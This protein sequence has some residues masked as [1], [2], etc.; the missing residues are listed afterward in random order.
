MIKPFKNLSNRNIKELTSIFNPEN[1][2]I[3]D[4]YKLPGVLY[5]NLIKDYNSPTMFEKHVIKLS[6]N[7]ELYESLFYMALN[8]KKAAREIA[9]FMIKEPNIGKL[10]TMFF[11]LTYMYRQSIEL[12]MKALVFKLITDENKQKEFIK[13]ISH[14][15]EKIIEYIELQTN[16]PHSE[17]SLFIWL[18]NFL[19]NISEFDR[20]SDSFRYPFR[21]K[22]NSALK[23][24]KFEYVF[25]KRKDICIVKLVNKFELAFDIFHK[26]YTLSKEGFSSYMKNESIHKKYSSEF[27]EEDGYYYA[28]SVIGHEYN[29]SDMHLYVYSYRTSADYLFDLTLKNIRDNKENLSD[30]YHLPICYLYRNAIELALKDLCIT[31]LPNTDALKAIYNK[32]HNLESMWNYIKQKYV[33]NLKY[34]IPEDH[35]MEID[36]VLTLIHTG[37]P[38]S[39]K[40]RYPFDQSLNRYYP[41][42]SRIHLGY[43][44]YSLQYCL[45]IIEGLTDTTRDFIDNMETYHS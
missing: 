31:S 34:E 38:T 12:I 28:K 32:K 4:T 44:Y 36:K 24:Y 15:L 5:N 42:D 41:N 7:T 21:I 27:L 13:Q 1:N 43:D 29:Q 6:N 39:S 40:F 17:S 18:K 10:D 19:T 16:I 30:I 23:T 26:A 3:Q 35:K 2:P 37:D 45:D 8:F 25:K 33:L 20:A 22:R 11:T 14:D 9:D